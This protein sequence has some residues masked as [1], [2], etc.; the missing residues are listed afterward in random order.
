MRPNILVVGLNPVMQKTI[1]LEH[2]LENE[3]NRSSTYIFS[4]AGKGGNTSRVLTELNANIIHLTHGGGIFKETFRSMLENDGIHTEIVDSGSEIRLCYTLIN[5]ERNTATEIVEEALPIDTET[6]ARMRKAYLAWIDMVK[7]VAIC[8]TKATGYSSDI[9]PWMVKTATEN[10]KK[11]VLDVKGNDLIDSISFKPTVIKP[12][13][14]EFIDTFFPQDSIKEQDESSVVLDAVKQKMLDLK[15]D[16]G[17]TTVLTRGARP[18]LF[19][20]EKAIK[21]SAVDKVIPVNTIG[22]G[23]AFTAGISFALS[24]NRSIADCVNIGIACGKANAM[25]LQPGTIKGG[26]IP[27]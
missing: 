16:V 26:T 22:S 20:E 9:I 19:C 6:D 21:E 11:V 15:K 23:D 8:G 14:K 24:E 17:I 12:N 4:V 25:N 1:V 5:K 3:V 13:L 10:N 27:L 2:L 7:V 18:V